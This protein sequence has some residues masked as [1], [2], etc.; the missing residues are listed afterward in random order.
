MLKKKLTLAAWLLNFTVF[1]LTAL[2]VSLAYQ[3]VTN[4]EGFTGENE[5]WCGTVAEKPFYD[6][7]Y[8]EEVLHNATGRT[9]FKNNCE[10]CHAF[11]EV[12]VGPPLHGI[13]DRHSREWVYEFV[14]NSTEMIEKKDSSSVAIYEKYARQQ[15]PSFTLSK[16]ELD[17]LFDYINAQPDFPAFPI[18]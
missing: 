3:V 14:L 8:V 4:T 2:I 11:H 15:M 17:S 18:E 5:A 13:M 16:Q 7:L 10:P 6:V 12:V 9:L 1:A